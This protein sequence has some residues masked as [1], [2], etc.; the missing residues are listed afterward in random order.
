MPCSPPAKTKGLKMTQ[1]T[2]P[3]LQFYLREL[4]QLR[5]I[6]D[7]HYENV[8]GGIQQRLNQLT[9]SQAKVEEMREALEKLE[10]A[11]RPHGRD[12]AGNACECENC[13]SWDACIKSLSTSGYQLLEELEDLRGRVK[14]AEGALAVN[15]LKLYSQELTTLKS[16][17]KFIRDEAD[18]IDI[19]E[20]Q[21]IHKA[22]DS[23]MTP[24]DSEKKV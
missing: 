24:N 1:I 17:L 14:Y 2:D 10:A 9:L 7:M 3:G 4:H 15:D 13:E 23:A 16:C 5:P 22:I 6:A 12:H 11:G 18:F 8:A 20:E 21:R 19:E